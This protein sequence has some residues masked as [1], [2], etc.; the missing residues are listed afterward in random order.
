MGFISDPIVAIAT[1]T[2]L[3]G[4]GIVRVSGK[5]LSQFTRDLFGKK[6]DP[7]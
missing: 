5:D 7:R 4:I 1:A 6:L 2:G 3:G